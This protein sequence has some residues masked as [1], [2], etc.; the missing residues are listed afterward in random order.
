[1][2]RPHFSDC[3]ES[4]DQKTTAVFQASTIGVGS[5]IAMLRK[6]TLRQITMSKMEF[7]PLEASLKSTS[8]RI[9]KILLHTLYIFKSHGFRRPGQMLTKSDGRRRDRLPGTGVIFRNMVISLPW[10]VGIRLTSGMRNLNTRNGASV[11]DGLDNRN[12]SLC[13]LIIPQTGT[14]WGNATFRSDGC[15]FDND[16]PSPTPSQGTIVNMVPVIHD[17]I[18]GHILAH[19]GNGDT[20]TQCN[21]LEGKRLEQRG[22]GYD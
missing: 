6:E 2:F 10:T 12:K 11:L 9:N 7:N 21:V 15:R 17:P 13:L 20:I 14:L 4:F 3:R 22:R 5:L 19:R 1:M 16:Q 18:R 8:R